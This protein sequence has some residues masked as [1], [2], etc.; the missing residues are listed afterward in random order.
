MFQKIAHKMFQKISLQIF[1]GYN[2][3]ITFIPHNFFKFEKKK[4]KKLCFA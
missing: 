4:K 3:K 2:V 1:Q